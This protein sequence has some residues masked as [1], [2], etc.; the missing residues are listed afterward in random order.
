[1]IKLLRGIVLAQ[2]EAHPREIAFLSLVSACGLLDLMF[3]RDER[4]A[5]GQK[6][7]ELVVFHAM[8]NPTLDTIQEIDAAI[9]SMVEED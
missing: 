9:A 6:I 5:A 2:E 4:K 8:Q 3:L 1:V 7:N